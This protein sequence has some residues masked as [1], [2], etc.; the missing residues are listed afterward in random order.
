MA[1]TTTGK[2]TEFRQ[3]L[4]R[5]H[6]VLVLTGAGISAESGV[7]TF[8]GAGGL[9]RQY[10]ATD[11]ATATAFSRS[12]SL[13]WE[14]YHYRR[15]LVRTKQPN[16]AHIALA[17]AERNFEKQ[18]KRFN[19]VT[20]NVDGLHRRAGTKNLIEM[21]GN[22]FMVRC[23]LCGFIEENNSSPICESLRNRGLSD[24]NGP[25]IDE[26]DLPRCR[27]CKSLARPHIVWFG[28]HI[29][30]DV[31]EKIEKE[32]QLCDLFLVVGT[33][34]VVYPAAGYASI[35]AQKNVPIAE[36]NI[37]TTP[38]T[39][40]AT[41]HFHGPAAQLLPQLLLSNIDDE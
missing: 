23:T 7:P 12:P 17:Q 41:Y 24:E 29:W 39:S 34:S 28:E 11:L 3:L 9:W 32:I 37:E 35:L 20:Q 38:S 6:S 15:E 40:I 10:R 5:A 1:S 16:K 8:R 21:H 4:S 2:I 25:D 22:L 14:F 33:S 19:V 27:K 36:V 31:L 30:D 26:K 13:V 18:G